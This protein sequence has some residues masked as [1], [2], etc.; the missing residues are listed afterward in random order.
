MQVSDFQKKQKAREEARKAA[1]AEGREAVREIVAAGAGVGVVS[2][3]EFGVD[4]RLCKIMIKDANITMDEAL[5]CLRE[6]LDSKL[7]RTFM[8]FAKAAAKI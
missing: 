7:I 2:E 3:A 8:P 6:R 5:I 4:H 1:E